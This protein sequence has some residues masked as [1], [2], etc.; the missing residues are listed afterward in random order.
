V[1][2]PASPPIWSRDRHGERRNRLLMRAC[3]TDCVRRWFGANGFF[4]VDTAALQ[5]SPG[6]ETHLHGF[7]TALVRPDGLASE[8]YLHTSAEFAMKKL[9]AAGETQIFSLSHVFRNRERTALHA[10]EFTMLEWYRVGAPL[11]RLIDDCAL[12]LA[13]AAHVAGARAFVFRGREASPF[14]PPERLTV[15]EAFQRHVGI[16]LYESQLAGKDAETA[17]LARQA[18]KAGIRVAADDTWSDIFSRLLSERVEAG[19]GAGRATILYDYP[20]SEA[21]LAQTSADD[22]RIAERFELYCCGVELANAFHELLDA[23]EQRRRFE[24]EMAEQERIYGTS[25]PIDVDF[26]DALAQMPD[27]CGA[28]LGFDRLVMLATGAERVDAV[29]WTPVFDPETPA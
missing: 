12:L 25:Y 13:L 14:E 23:D 7:R 28:A 15:R 2:A 4:E 20:A 1:S 29:Q 3:I 10:P 26:L 9:L 27:A 8:A 19:L 11:A 22:W 24:A 21:A 17:L 18:M 16:D 5:A 6:N